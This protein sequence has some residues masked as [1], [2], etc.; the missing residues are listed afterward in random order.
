[1]KSIALILTLIIIFVG[2]SIT[3]GLTNIFVAELTSSINSHFTTIAFYAADSGI[4][5][6]L[7]QDRQG[8]GL[9]DQDSISGILDNTS[10]YNYFVSGN[11]PNRTV[12][13]NGAYQGA[14]R[15]VEVSY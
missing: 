12:E 4:E 11:S 1:M 5:A 2:L 9:N 8:A 15:S 7:W 3:L 13:S 10:S 14:T 6:A